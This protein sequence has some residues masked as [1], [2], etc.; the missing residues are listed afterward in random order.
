MREVRYDSAWGWSAAA[1]IGFAALVC[2]APLLSGFDWTVAGIA[3]ICFLLILCPFC[4]TYYKIVEGN[5]IVYYCFYSKKYPV[6]KIAEIRPTKTWLSAPAISLSKR[7]AI[8]FSDR[9]V[10]KSSMPLVI[11]PA[12]QKDFI[13]HLRSL[14]PDIKL[15]F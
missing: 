15:S 10:L 9:N 8:T 4:G 3:A 6:A 5:L 2:F 14:N 12:K 13:A 1:V 11:S 7:I